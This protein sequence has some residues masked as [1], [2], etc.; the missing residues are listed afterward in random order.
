MKDC[1][2]EATFVDVGHGTS[3]VLRF[4]P[5]DVWLYDCGRMGNESGSSR[6][7]DAVLWSMGVTSLRGIFLSHADSDHYNAVPGVL[8]RFTV[9]QIITPPG[10]LAELE[11]D[12]EDV[13]AAIRAA[14]IPN[15]QVSAGAV[16]EVSGRAISVLHPPADRLEG[17]DNANSL[18]VTAAHAGVTLILPG[19]LEPPG[20][21]LLVN[22]DRPAPGSV[23]MAPHHGSLTMDASS[24]LQWARPRE[25]IVSGG[26]RA[27]RPEVR[28]MLAAFGSAVHV[29][30][31]VGAIRVRI[32]K[33]GQVEIRSWAQS[34]W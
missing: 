3:V 2:I 9:G 7:I 12:L 11:A 23:L 32:D 30:A 28:H 26:R 24:M 29:T 17:S 4:S 22:Q 6:D 19:D 21:V 27:R 31:E 10:M 13:R 8:R 33:D 16:I 20:T 1:A 25:T 14:G 18:V 5:R 15:Q 34:P